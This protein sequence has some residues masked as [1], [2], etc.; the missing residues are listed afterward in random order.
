MNPRQRTIF[1]IA[2]A[3]PVLLAVVFGLV[4]H[5]QDA[6]AVAGL[7]GLTS[8]AIFMYMDFRIRRARPSM[9]NPRQRKIRIAVNLYIGFAMVALLTVGTEGWHWYNFGYLIFPTLVT[10]FLF[11]SKR[12]NQRDA[13]E[14]V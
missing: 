8:A 5:I 7:M 3:I 2:L 6:L 4:N 13:A 12:K 10:V 11:N 1:A 14:K 9:E